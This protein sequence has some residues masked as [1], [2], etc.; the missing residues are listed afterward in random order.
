MNKIVVAIDFSECSINAFLHAISIAEHCNSELILLWVQKTVGEK[1][2][3]QNKP[4]I[5]T[6]DVQKAFEELIAK[7]QPDFPGIKITWK[8]REGKI[9]KEVTEEAKAVKAMLIVTGTHGAAGFEEFWIGSNA[10]KIVSSSYCPVITIRG[11]INI[12]R[13]LM[14]IVLP[15]DSAEETR[16]KSSFAGYIAKKHDAEIYILK[17]YT[18]KLKAMRQKVDIY[19]AQVKEYFDGE[20]IKYHVDHMVCENISDATIEY[21]AKIDANLIVIMTEQETKTSN[22]FLGPYAHQMVNHS[23][24]PVLSIH[25]KDTLATGTGF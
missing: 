21:A 12:Q 24:F 18:S 7:Y 11:G 16:Q 8:I 25:A 2:K 23:P 13:P 15:I 6:Q 5:P 3:Y 20:K 17:L 4:V 9:Y 10:N 19:T 1:E 14:K 22:I